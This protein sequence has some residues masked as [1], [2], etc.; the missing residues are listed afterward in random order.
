M[1]HHVCIVGGGSAIAQGLI[2]YFLDKG[3][4]VTAVCY[5]AGPTNPNRERLKILM[6]MDMAVG[7]NAAKLGDLDPIHVLITLM[8]SVDN[9]LL[10]NMKAD[11]WHAVLHSTLTSVFQTLRAAYP[12]LATPSNVIVVGS[13]VGATGGRGCANYAAAK[14][15]LKGLVRATANEWSGR[16]LEYLGRVVNLLELGYCNLGMGTMLG[17]YKDVLLES[18]PLGRFADMEDIIPA[19]EFLATT[20][21]CTGNV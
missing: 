15:A 8:G 19:I 13:I 7:T 11:Q 6:G 10:E 14:E 3:D 5:R 2:D 16:G 18:I 9:S 4:R 1:S 17:K 21:Y 20:R 12:A